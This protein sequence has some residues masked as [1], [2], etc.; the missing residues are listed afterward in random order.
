M[1]SASYLV[2]RKTAHL[3]KRVYRSS[4]AVRPWVA[5]F[6]ALLFVGACFRCEITALGLAALIALMFVMCPGT[7][8][9]IS[10]ST[11]LWLLLFQ[12][13]LIGIGA[14]LGGNASSQ[15]SL[16][17]QIPFLLIGSLF[18]A[19][20]LTKDKEIRSSELR[21]PWI[22]VLLAL[23]AVFFLVG[24]ADISSKLVAIRNLVVFYMAYKIAADQCKNQHQSTI[25]LKSLKNVALVATVAGIF[26]MVQS[27]DFWQGIGI[28]E[29]YIAK[30]SPITPG[31]LG[32]RFYTNLDG[33]TDLLRMGSLYYEPVNLAYLLLAGLIASFVLYRSGRC[34]IYTPA[35]ILLGFVLTFGKGGYLLLALIICSAFANQLISSLTGKKPSDTRLKS[36]LICV[37]VASVFVYLYYMLIGGAA[38]P[39]F[40]ALEQ[41]SASI[42]A[43]PF[44][45][46]LGTGGNM[47]VAGSDYSRGAE[48]AVMT[49]GYQIGILGIICVF[50]VL[51]SIAQ[52]AP[53]NESWTSHV[54]FYIPLCLFA[55]S[56]LQEN[57]FSPQC[58]FPFMALTA[59]LDV[60]TPEHEVKVGAIEHAEK[61]TQK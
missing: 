46:G 3:N 49:I 27:V 15:L 12:N 51:Y 18:F 34:R 25:V 2:D 54:A 37:L 28:Y 24:G 50:M 32:G 40:W 57:T 19:R 11:C 10:V 21:T 47:S 60:W 4:L 52:C 59:T 58:I 16:L 23:I 9:N 41:A 43:N 30:Q 1:T 55:V 61:S 36:F 17:T 42:A 44:G 31:T 6:S 39:H 14:H 29:V 38:R 7:S 22:W 45:H 5:L 13:T 8:R 20:L 35:L 56:I 48:S 53:K 26:L 33:S